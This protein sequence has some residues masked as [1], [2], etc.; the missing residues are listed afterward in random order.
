MRKDLL[1]IILIF[2]FLSSNILSAQDNFRVLPY[3]QN[4]GPNAITILWFSEEDSPGLLS[5]WK[6]D[7]ETQISVNSNPISAEAIAYSTWEDTTYFEGQ[8]PSIPFRHRIRIENLEPATIYEYAVTQG[9]KSF[10]SSFRT[11]PKGNTS[12]RFIVYA[13]S[14]TEPESN[15]NYTNWVDPISGSPRSYIIDQTLG[16]QNNLDV[17]KLRQPDIVF[18]AG[19]L[20]ETG[21]EQRDWDEF[22]R[23]N[24][25]NNSELGIASEVPI[26][27]ALGNH[28]YFEGPYLDQYNQPGSERAVKRFL[29]YFESPANN[30]PNVEQEGRYYCV[31][32]G[33]ATFIVLD[34]CNNSPNKSGDDTNFYLL[35]ENDSAGG[36]APDFGPGSQQYSWLEAR[37]IES[38]LNSMFT[39]VI[40]HHA[41]YSSGPHGYPPGEVKYTDNQSGNPVR[42]LTPVFMKYG[43]DA[44]FSGHDE[45]WERSEVSGIEIKPD[46]SE[47]MHTIH[48][49]DVGIAGDG[50]REPSKGIDNPN[51]KFLVHTDVPEVWENNVLISGGKHYGHLEVDIIPEDTNIWKAIL[52]PVYI[53]PLYDTIDSTYSNYERRIYEDQIILTRSYNDIVVPVELTLFSAILN[54]NGILLDWET[55][56]ETGNYGFEL[57]RRIESEWQKVTFLEG[58][59]TTSQPNQYEYLDTS[60]RVL[61]PNIEPFYRLKQIDIDGNYYYSDSIH[62]EKASLLYSTTSAF[63]F[64]Q[65]YPNPFNLE[66]TIEYDLLEPCYI[67]VKI[68]NLQGKIIRI[69]Y[70]GKK[71]TG[72]YKTIWDGKDESGNRVT[73]GLYLYRIET[74]SGQTQSKRMVLL[75]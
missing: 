41:P 58:N 61:N 3:L 46:Q 26:M 51:Q 45:M 64:S 29:T 74:S 16:Y 43:V 20:V 75:K 55:Q 30:S 33:P 65:S 70:D 63:S 44:V 21:G 19:D 67:T 22:W 31:K 47:K 71:S 37:L 54:N 12:I 59:G 73:S 6:Q 9:T 23:H 60:A 42:L 5:Y 35:G 38:Q 57:Q 69:L 68:F 8:A 49:Y 1:I 7:T 24:T 53:F 50:L 13:D 36:N 18:I 34:V 17:M 2:T 15:G 27:A 56:T 72:F 66:T 11:A 62:V 48:F 40:M 10:S 14:E 28:D 52:K 25:N 4:P 32:Y 39:F